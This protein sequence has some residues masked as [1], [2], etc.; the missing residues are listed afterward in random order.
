MRICKLCP[1]G[2]IGDECHYLLHCDRFKK[3]RNKYIKQLDKLGQ[4]PE[5]IKAM[6]L[7]NQEESYFDICSFAN[8]KMQ[9]FSKKI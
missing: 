2:S 9:E 6:H 1:S 4:A 8:I 7:F 3:E 5:N